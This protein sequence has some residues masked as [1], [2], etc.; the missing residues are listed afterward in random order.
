MRKLRVRTRLR[1]PAAACAAGL[2][3]VA[4]GVALFAGGNGAD[5]PVGD[6]GVI[7][8]YNDGSPDD[9]VDA[10][11]DDNR[12]GYVDED[13]SGW[14]CHTMGNHVCGPRPISGE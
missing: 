8:V 7:T 6:T 14:D 2:S 1:R 11:G 5:G 4:L 13:E 12:D 3:A 9:R 10:V